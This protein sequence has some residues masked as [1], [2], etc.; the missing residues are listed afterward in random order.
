MVVYCSKLLTSLR[1]LVKLAKRENHWQITRCSS[2]FN[3]AVRSASIGK[4]SIAW[5]SAEEFNLLYIICPKITKCHSVCHSGQEY[6]LLHMIYKIYLENTRCCS[7]RH[8]GQAGITWGTANWLLL[9]H[10][11]R[12]WHYLRVPR[13][14]RWFLF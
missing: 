5:G 8:S 14:S 12:H 10:T 4:E 13:I 6:N 2:V 7:V 1:R 9:G 3:E 11:C